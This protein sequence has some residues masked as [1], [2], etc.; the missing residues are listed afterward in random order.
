LASCN[1]IYGQRFGETTVFHLQ[2]LFILKMEATDPSVVLASIYNSTRLQITEGHN[3]KIT[4]KVLSRFG[5]LKL[6]VCVSCRLVHQQ[7]QRNHILAENVLKIYTRKVFLENAVL[8][9]KR[10]EEDIGKP[11]FFCFCSRTP[12]ISLVSRTKTSYKLLFSREGRTN[13]LFSLGHS[14]SSSSVS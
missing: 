6:C 2:A 3:I 14:S 5:S 8:K 4:C 11:L 7:K 1:L 10:G 12:S 13:C 9:V